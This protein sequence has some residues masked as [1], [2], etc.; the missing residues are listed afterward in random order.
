MEGLAQVSGDSPGSRR[1]PYVGRPP[2]EG[3]SPYGGRSGVTYHE[4]VLPDGLDQLP[5]RKVLNVGI[6]ILTTVNGAEE[7]NRA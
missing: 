4:A 3:R 2:Y 1:S 7:C 6:V 5:P